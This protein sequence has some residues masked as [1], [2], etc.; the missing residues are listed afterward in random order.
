ML[1]TDDSGSS[2]AKRRSYTREFKL[3][4]LA[5]YEAN[6]RNISATARQFEV[7]P[8]RIREWRS[9]M[10]H[11]QNQAG[12]CRAEGRGR[13]SFFPLMEKRLHEEFS[14][15][16]LEGKRVKRWWFTARARVL[17]KDL[18]PD[19]SNF[20]FSEDWFRRFRVRFIFRKKTHVAQKAPQALVQAISDFHQ[21]IHAVRESGVFS[22]AD[23]A[24][25]DQTPLPG[26]WKDVQ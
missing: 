16:R 25:M 15:Q 10:E 14:Q 7:A 26:W 6:G 13:S 17:M 20:T 11:I 5:W 9:L 23:L 1:L 18:Y 2:S 3:N 19:A 24:N 4:A 21:Q 12:G 8:K 22:A